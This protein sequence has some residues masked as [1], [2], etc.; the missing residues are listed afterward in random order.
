MLYWEVEYGCPSRSKYIVIWAFYSA[1][2]CRVWEVPRRSSSWI[3]HVAH[4][5]C[6]QPGKGSTQYIRRWSSETGHSQPNLFEKEAKIIVLHHYWESTAEEENTA[7]INGKLYPDFEEDRKAKD[8]CQLQSIASRFKI[9]R[10]KPGI[11]CSGERAG[12]KHSSAVKR[13]NDSTIII[14]HQQLVS[15]CKGQSSRGSPIEISAVWAV[16]NIRK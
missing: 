11:L 8:W 15:K 1:G 16:W 10:V 12:A 14:F 9:E 6:R 5:T 13:I 4:A 3:S 7:I 2:N